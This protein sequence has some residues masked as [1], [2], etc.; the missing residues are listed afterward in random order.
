MLENLDTG[1]GHSKLVG[2]ASDGFGLYGTR[3]TNG[4]TVNNSDLDEC[5]GHTHKVKFNGKKQRIYHY[6]LTAEYPYT[7]GCY[8]GTPVSTNG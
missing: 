2:Y 7:I 5:H 6:H 8:R 3:G 1:S 4:E